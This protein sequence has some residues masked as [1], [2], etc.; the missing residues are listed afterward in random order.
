MTPVTNSLTPDDVRREL[1]RCDYGRNTRW[2]TGATLG[3]LLFV[4]GYCVSAVDRTRG[5]LHALE[6]ELLQ[7]RSVASRVDERL[8]GVEQKLDRVLRVVEK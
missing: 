7:D 1:A 5:D 3:V 4:I 8:K 2:F 6:R